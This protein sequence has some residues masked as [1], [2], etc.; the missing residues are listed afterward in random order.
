MIQQING[1]PF[2]LNITA[3]ALSGLFLLGCGSDT[4]GIDE[5]EATPPTSITGWQM[6]WQDEFDGTEVDSSKWSFAVDCFGGGNDEAQCYTARAENSRVAE[7]LLTITALRETFSG[8]AVNDSDPNYDPLDTSKTLD[9]TSARLVSKN[10]GDWKYGRFEIRAKLPQGQGTWP[11]IWMLPTDWVYGPWAGSGEIDIMEA[12]NLTTV[13]NGGEPESA[14]HGTLHFGKTWPNNVYSGQD[15]ALPNAQNPSDDFH[16]YALEWQEDEIRWYVDDVHYATQRSSGW[17]SQYI[18]ENGNTANAPDDAPFNQQFHMLLNLA[19]GGSWAANV[20]NTGID[21]SVFPQAM[22]IDYV[23]VYE[24]ADSPNTGAG[25]ATIDDA[26]IIV[27]G[28]SAPEIVIPDTQFGQGPT[29]SLFSYA[30]AIALNTDLS[31]GSYNPDGAITYQVG[32][33]D[34]R[35][36]R[37]MKIKMDC[38]TP[39]S[40]GDFDIMPPDLGVWT[41]YD[42]ALTDLLAN[43]GSSLDLAKVDTPIVIFPK[44]GDQQGVVLQIDNIKLTQ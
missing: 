23:R 17:Y 27:P 5:V 13:T 40:S 11:A 30:D 1:L 32:S 6:V 35:E 26:A 37:S 34:V 12:V 43:N 31:F 19:V 33:D 9:Y 42:I 8:P 38:Q 14:V 20:N 18:D 41:H 15:Y 3:I 4:S 29:F 28:H 39:C 44:W 25:C 24:C 22:Q 16:V 21:E 36:V 2:K 10:K 7:G